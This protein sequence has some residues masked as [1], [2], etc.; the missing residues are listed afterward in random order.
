MAN[1]KG[2]ISG[3]VRGD[4][5]E[6]IRAIEGIVDG[7]GIVEAWFTVKESYWSSTPLI[8]KNITAVEQAGIGMISDIGDTSGTA[9]IKFYLEP[10]DTLALQEF[11]DYVY[12]IQLKT[13]AGNVYTTESGKIILNPS[14]TDAE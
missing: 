2:K 3:V 9:Q 4:N 7:Q 12:D 8:E 11:Y 6:V 10:D 1:L 5:S 14:V 13:E